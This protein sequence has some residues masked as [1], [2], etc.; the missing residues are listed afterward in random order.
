MAGVTKLAG[1]GEA[2]AVGGSGAGDQGAFEA[3]KGHDQVSKGRAC[4]TQ[5]GSV[6]C[7]SGTIQSPSVGLAVC[8]G[9][10]RLRSL[11]FPVNALQDRAVTVAHGGIPVEIH[12]R[13]NDLVKA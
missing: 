10:A 4:R 6:G 2:D 12:F 13:I 11:F 7:I 5:T 1:N 9:L 3:G 8:V